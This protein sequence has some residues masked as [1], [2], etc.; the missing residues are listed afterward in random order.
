MGTTRLTAVGISH[1][2]FKCA[3][4]MDMDGDKNQ[5][6]TSLRNTKRQEGQTTGTDLFRVELKK[7]DL[8][9]LGTSYLFF[10]LMVRNGVGTL[11][12][13][14]THV[15]Q[16]QRKGLQRVLVV[17]SPY[18]VET[19]SRTCW[20]CSWILNDHNITWCPF[21]SS[22]EKRRVR[23]FHTPRFGPTHDGF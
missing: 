16:T 18:R 22:V 19:A 21:H 17:G 2:F 9:W 10:S 4:F 8:S 12:L 11:D 14:T 7:R 5:P 15:L 13:C 1:S 3:G 20:G 23:R 6:T